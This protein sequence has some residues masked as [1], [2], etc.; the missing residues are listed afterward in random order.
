MI[1]LLSERDMTAREISQAVGIREKLVY[2]HLTHMARSVAT[3]GMNLTILPFRCL[4]CGH[5]FR[6]RRR[7][8]PP[9]R[10]PR[11]KKS[12][13]ERPTYRVS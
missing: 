4:N 8:T 7:F 9:G 10:C 12:H 2:G 5:V 13:I 6:E 1:A 11:C 3:R